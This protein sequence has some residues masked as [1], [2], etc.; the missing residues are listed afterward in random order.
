[1]QLFGVGIIG[2]I[3]L[4]DGQQL[5]IFGETYRAVCRGGLEFRIMDI[6]VL[7]LTKIR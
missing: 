7:N 1:M 6:A 4:F 3:V 2:C 5:F